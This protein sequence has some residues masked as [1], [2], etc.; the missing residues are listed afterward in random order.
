V[1]ALVL[2]GALAGAAGSV[3][4][5][6]ATWVAFFGGDIPLLPIHFTGFSLLRGAAWLF[7]ADPVAF[8]IL[9]TLFSLVIAPFTTVANRETRSRRVSVGAAVLSVVIAAALATGITWQVTSRDSEHAVSP[10]NLYAHLDRTLRVSVPG[11]YRPA[12]SVAGTYVQIVCTDDDGYQFGAFNG[13]SVTPVN[14]DDLDTQITGD[15]PMSCGQ[16]FGLHQSIENT[17]RY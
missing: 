5:A 10:S 8:G 11:I 4:S 9:S 13:K 12:Y 3:W 2:V 17:P 7:F 6:W 15:V 1:V 14:Q 16:W